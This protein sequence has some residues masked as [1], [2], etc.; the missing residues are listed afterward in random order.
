MNEHMQLG[1]KGATLIKSFESLLLTAYVDTYE[2]GADGREIKDENGN[3][4]PILACGYGHTYKS[5]PPAVKEGD[6]WTE[7][8]ADEVFLADTAEAQRR[9]HRDVKVPLSQ[10][11]YDA[12][13]SF[14]FNSSTGSWK[15]FIA[16]SEINGGNFDLVRPTLMRY[17]I[18]RGRVLRGLVR[19]RK[20]EADLFDLK[21]P[22]TA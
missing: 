12:L 16:M 20:E 8:Y 5:G 22:E 6:V 10:N 11:Q 14:A 18:S 9:I 21:E 2:R 15:E 4:I 7:A 17:V 1:E 3:P 13:T 19:R